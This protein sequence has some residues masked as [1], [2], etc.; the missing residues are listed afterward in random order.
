M[1][2]CVHDWTLAALNKSVDTQ[3]YWYAFDSVA[4]SVNNQDWES[5]KRLIFAPVS[6]Y[7][8]RLVHHRFYKNNLTD[9]M[10]TRLDDAVCIAELLKQQVQL[11]AAEQMYGRALAGYE[12]VLGRDY[13]STLDTVNNLGLLYSDQGKLVEMIRL[14]LIWGI[15]SV[16]LF[17]KLGRLL[18]QIQDDSNAQIAFLHEIQ[19]QDNTL[20]FAN[21]QC[22]GCGLPILCI[23]KRFVCRQCA[24]SDLC[25]ECWKLLKQ[26]RTRVA[27]CVDHTFL[28]ISL[29]MSSTHKWCSEG[30]D[31]ALWLQDLAVKY[32]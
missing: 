21:I 23:K 1:Y 29:E 30:R 11:A 7:A 16:N 32:S 22:D 2:T 19:D 27:T 26:D 28:S 24:D 4:V 9:I 17:G 12:A 13:T 14:V 31:R 15:E 3:L 6:A 25:G 8:R 5:F 18:L 10:P 20:Y